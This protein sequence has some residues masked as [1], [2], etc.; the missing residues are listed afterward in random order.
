[1]VEELDQS[2]IR[3]IE[4]FVIAYMVDCARHPLEFQLT[5]LRTNEYWRHKWAI[6][7]VNEANLAWDTIKP[8]KDDNFKL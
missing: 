5:E 8:L 2:K 4:Q 6:K 7:A 1:M 3:F